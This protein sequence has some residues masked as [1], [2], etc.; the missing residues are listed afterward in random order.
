MSIIYDAL[1]KLEG[2]KTNPSSENIS[3]GINSLAGKGEKSLSKIRIISLLIAGL[4]LVSLGLFAVSF[5]FSHKEQIAQKEEIKTPVV[6]KIEIDPKRVYKISGF[7]S[8]AAEE[9]I[10]EEEPVQEYILEGIIFDPKAPFALINGKVIKESDNLDNLRIDKISKSKV[11]MT[12]TQDNN[13]V[14]LF[15]SD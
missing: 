9:A 13:K 1:K 6:D 11:E 15:L 12:N 5:I 2:K 7:K 8:Q 4:L 3:Q 14:T 10:L